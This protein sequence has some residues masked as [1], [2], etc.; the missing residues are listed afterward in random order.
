[1]IM[2]KLSYFPGVK[3]GNYYP[4]RFLKRK[5]MYSHH[6][7]IKCDRHYPKFKPLKLF[8]KD[9]SS[10]YDLQIRINPVHIF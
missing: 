6:L 8:L 7:L 2:E 3:L 10:S 9:V 1:M 5:N 4:A